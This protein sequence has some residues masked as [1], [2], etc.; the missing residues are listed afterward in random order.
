MVSAGASQ[1]EGHV[2]FHA[3]GLSVR[4][5]RVLHVSA[6]VLF[7]LSRFSSYPTRYKNMH[8]RPIGTVELSV[9]VC[10]SVNGCMSIIL[11]ILAMKYIATFVN[12]IHWPS[13]GEGTP[14]LCLHGMTMPSPHDKLGRLQLTPRSAGGSGNRR[15]IDGWKNQ[16]KPTLILHFKYSPYFWRGN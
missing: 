14:C 8:M 7:S 1:Q 2:W 9:G 12:E 4:T 10:I 15:W 16:M 5:L 11:L 13:W 6:W 3:W